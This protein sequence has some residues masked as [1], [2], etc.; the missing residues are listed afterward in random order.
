MSVMDLRK[1]PLLERSLAALREHQGWLREKGVIHAAVFG[2]VARGD[3]DDRSDID[4]LVELSPEA[5]VGTPEMLQIED[6]LVAA[7]GRRVD[8]VSRGG[9][10]SPRHDHILEEMIAA[11]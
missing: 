1:S 5:R 11:F 3:D 7:F 6:A 10:K 4:V 9:L 2:S 8:V